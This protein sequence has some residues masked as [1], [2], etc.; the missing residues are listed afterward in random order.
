MSKILIVEDNMDIAT[1]LK[2]LLE[3]QKYEVM[4]CYDG[5]QGNEIAHKAMPDLILLDLMLPAGGGF[6][7]LEKLKLSSLTKFIPIIVLTASKEKEHREKALAAGVEAFIEKPYDNAE[8]LDTIK[9]I[10]G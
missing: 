8:L 4:V 10:L 3:S 2:D 5:I 7:V 6:Y 1:L 9:K